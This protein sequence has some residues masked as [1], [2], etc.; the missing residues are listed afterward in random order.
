MGDKTFF[1]NI[2]R[3]AN[4][5]LSKVFDKVEVVSKT[6]V[7]KLRISDLKGKIRDHKVE[8]GEF[9]ISNKKKFTEFPEIVE[10]L[11][12][13]KLLEKQIKINKEQVEKLQKKVKS[14]KVAKENESTSS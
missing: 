14:E 12:K 11:D 2:K 1:E 13:I 5:V 10:T 8:I 3:E 6:S 9:V 7:L 4:T